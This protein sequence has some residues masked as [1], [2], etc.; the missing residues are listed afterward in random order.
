MNNLMY[1]IIKRALMDDVVKPIQ[2]NH[3]QRLVTPIIL[4]DNI[5]EL[6]EDGIFLKAMGQLD[7]WNEISGWFHANHEDG[8]PIYRKV[9]C[10]IEI[11]T[12]IE[13]RYWDGNPTGLVSPI[14]AGA[15]AVDS[16]Y[17]LYRIY[18]WG[19]CDGSS[20]IYFDYI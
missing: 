20:E 17:N 2:H 3:R 16:E 18:G 19:K 11:P 9:G 7:F 14:V 13:E 6:I 5:T 4:V 1:N 8:H 15:Y 10:T 12:D